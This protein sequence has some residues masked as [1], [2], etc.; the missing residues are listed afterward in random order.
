MIRVFGISFVMLLTLTGC[1]DKLEL[2]EQAYVVVMGIDKSEQENALDIT[3]QIA[4]PQ[5]GSTD[6]AQ[7]EQ[8]PAS[9]IVTLTVP[10]V[11]SA[12]DTANA[13]VTRKI[14]LSHL[15]NIIISSELAESGGIGELVSSI[16][17]DRQMRRGIHML[18]SEER[19]SDF[20]RNSDSKLETRPHK[21]YELMQLRWEENGMVP[22]STI[23]QYL[24]QSDGKNA[25]F[26][27]A[28]ATAEEKEEHYGK[29]DE[30]TP[31]EMFI[32]GG[33]QVQVIGAKVIKEGKM[34]GTLTG[35]QTRLATLLRRGSRANHWFATF[36]D[37]LSEGD[38]VTARIL[39]DE[40]LK[41]DIDTDKDP[42]VI[43][44]KVP[45]KVQL[46][47]VPSQIDFVMDQKKQDILISSIEETLEK[48]A[49]QLI[50]HTQEEYK[51]DLFLWYLESRKNFRTTSDFYKYDWEEKYPQADVH[52]TF[53]VTL[54]SFGNRLKTMEL[55]GKGK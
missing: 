13:V 52:V 45:L 4:N 22:Y 54:E 14:T 55:N 21:Y 17:M 15:K 31:G 27:M 43:S 5:V 42:L 6:R 12:K 40:R 46:A 18:V 24:Q 51:D 26:L 28:Y 44:A 25:P 11:V 47:S 16:M 30:Y 20:I 34:I 41:V 23:N 32:Q 29:E 8:E 10:D 9:E 39:K 3:F 33:D 48:E 53:E 49:M 35:E 37:P 36:K 38:R 7:S 1:W 19:A 2:E 50:K